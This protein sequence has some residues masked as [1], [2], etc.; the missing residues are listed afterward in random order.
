MSGK[1]QGRAFVWWIAGALILIAAIL[2][3]AHINRDSIARRA[4]NSYLKEQGI[5]VDDVSIDN[6]S[7]NHVSFSSISIELENG[8]IVRVLDVSLPYDRTAESTNALTIGGLEISPGDQP[9]EPGAL[10]RMYEHA[11]NLPRTVPVAR[12]EVGKAQYGTAPPFE[13]ISWSSDDRNQSVDFSFLG[14]QFNADISVENQEPL[15]KLIAHDESDRKAIE[16]ELLAG[17]LDGNVSFNGPCEFDMGSLLPVLQVTGAMPAN[18]VELDA[19]FRGPVTVG[20]SGK[21]SNN[22]EFAVEPALEQELSVVYANDT[23]E[24]TKVVAHSVSNSRF[25]L[26][27]P[28]LEWQA[29][30]DNG[31]VVV[32]NM[33]FDGV[34]IGVTEATC[35][36]GIT[37]TMIASISSV[38]YASDSWALSNVSGTVPLMVD[39][40]DE[41]TVYATAESEFSGKLTLN[42]PGFGI[43]SVTSDLIARIRSLEIGASG[44]KIS[45]QADIRAEHDFEELQLSEFLV[46][47]RHPL[48][49]V[50]GT[51]SLSATVEWSTEGS[52]IA[53]DGSAS[54]TFREL[55]GNYGEAAIAGL[56]ADVE[57]RLDNQQGI[58]VSPTVIRA[59]LLEVGI[60]I[61]NVTAEI[62]PDAGAQTLHVSGLSMSALG[63]E[64]IARPFDYSLEEQSAVVMLQPESIQLQFIVSLAEFESVDITGSVSGLLPVNIRG[65]KVIIDGG[66]IESDEPGGVIR[67]RSPAGEEALDMDSQFGIVTRAL[68]NFQYESLL[69]DVDYSESGDLVLQ[70]TIK[71]INPDMDPNQ[72]VILNIG[73]ENNIPQLMRSLLATRSIEDILENRTNK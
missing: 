64:I 26:S 11:V 66:K 4:A 23:S 61:E 54:I 45:T 14:L 22:I 60:P 40:A 36:S 5:V 62:A 15:I 17:R 70:M 65:N 59:Q 68:S 42:N 8:A 43:E 67:Y 72:P 31:D 58:T 28:S 12:F 46:N 71:G 34:P 6:L 56:S 73:V 55:S 19:T 53:Y 63:G 41:S 7:A 44:Q 13:G 9:S 24:Q 21:D 39:I 37:C 69:S 57:L 35:S 3:A 52:E 32:S 1:S 48:N 2:L 47:W 51:A 20:L 25:Q 10:V 49:V 29:Q 18:I 33:D 27:Y 30:V 50:G 38:D 16:C